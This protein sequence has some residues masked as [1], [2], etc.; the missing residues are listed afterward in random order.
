VGRRWGD[1]ARGTTSLQ[2]LG[3]AVLPAGDVPRDIYRE[4]ICHDHGGCRV[5][6]GGLPLTSLPRAGAL[7]APISRLP[8]LEDIDA[9]VRQLCGRHL[10]ALGA[11]G[12]VHDLVCFDA[13]DLRHE[14]K[15]PLAL[16]GWVTPEKGGWSLGDSTGRCGIIFCEGEAREVRGGGRRTTSGG[17][18]VTRGR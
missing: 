7:S 14:C 13:E 8:A 15:A 3:H 17:R 11:G 9:A 18:C 4:I 16:A 2:T 10:V 12:A 1:Q 5:L 6:L